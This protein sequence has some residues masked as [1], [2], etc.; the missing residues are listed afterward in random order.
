MRT[1]DAD[2]LKV[3][4]KMKLIN[5]KTAD[6]IYSMLDRDVKDNIV[7]AFLEIDPAGH[8]LTADEFCEYLESTLKSNFEYDTCSSLPVNI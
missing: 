4:G 6:K 7:L 8:E 5:K 2:R 3:E 1:I